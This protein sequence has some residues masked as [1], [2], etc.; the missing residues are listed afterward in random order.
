MEIAG[1]EDIK[2]TDLVLCS[3]ADGRGSTAGTAGTE[4][5]GDVEDKATKAAEE[6]GGETALLPLKEFAFDLDSS[7]AEFGRL[8]VRDNHDYK[9]GSEFRQRDRGGGSA[10]RGVTLVMASRIDNGKQEVLAILF[11]RSQFDEPT[12]A[13]WWAAHRYRFMQPGANGLL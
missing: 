13:G 1:L 7:T 10:Q 5:S 2:A 12:A 4:A 3:E 11:D 8:C 9:Q 6:T